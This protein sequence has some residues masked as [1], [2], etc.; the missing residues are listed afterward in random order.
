MTPSDRTTYH[1][2]DMVLIVFPFTDARQMKKR[3][4]LVLFE[5]GNEDITLC[6]ITSHKPETEFDYC[7]ENWKTHGLLLPSVIRLNKIATLE[8]N[9][10]EKKLGKL[11][12]EEKTEVKSIFLNLINSAMT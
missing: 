5:S 10:I 4:A 7:I 3:P 11:S 6:R 9:L 8:N 2:G 12:I 1:F